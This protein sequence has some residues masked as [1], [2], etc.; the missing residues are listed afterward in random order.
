MGKYGV[1]ISRHEIEFMFTNARFN[2]RQIEYIRELCRL[3]GKYMFVDRDILNAR[4]K[5]GIGLSYIKKAVYYHIVTEMQE[6]TEKG[7]KDIY[8][9]QLGMGGK[10]ILDK[11]EDRYNNIRFLA[12]REE[13]SRILTFN[14]FAL[15]NNYDIDMR[16]KQDGEG[17]YFFCRNGIV[18]YYPDAIR[19]NKLIQ[20]LRRLLSTEENILGADEIREKFNFIPIDM[21]LIEIGSK[22]KTT[23]L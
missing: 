7:K 11:N 1:G 21:K 12:G 18:C 16:Y 3:L 22:T 14:Y 19:E 9:Y 23:L 5:N 10:Y 6:E 20:E 13:K 2:M 4:S 15:D 8:Y 17:R